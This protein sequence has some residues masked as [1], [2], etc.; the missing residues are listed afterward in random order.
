MKIQSKITLAFICVGAVSVI[1]TSLIIGWFSTDFGKKSLEDA[2]KNQLVSI[3]EIKKTQ[4]ENHF[5]FIEDQVKTSSNNRMIIDAMQEF[6]QAFHQYPDE[7]I[8]ADYEKYR[9]GLKDYY[10]NEFLK[11]Y[12]SVN[13][14]SSLDV[15]QI[16]SE[17]DNESVALQ[18]RYIKDN[19][20][21]LGSKDELVE[22]DGHTN[23][24][25]VH[26]KYH[27]HI[28][29]F[30]K[31]FGYYDI[32]LVDPVTGKIV[33]SVFKELDY[34][35]SL[36]DGPYADSGLAKAFKEANKLDKQDAVYLTD[37]KPYTPS[38]ESPAAFI[39]SPIYEGGIKQGILIFQ[40]PI[41]SINEIMTNNENWRS[42][43]LGE[44]GET[45]LVGADYKMRSQGRFIIEDKPAYIDLIESLGYQEDLVNSIKLKGTT[46]GLQEVES[47]GVKAALSGESGFSIFPDYR[48][49]TVLSAYA[50]V[51]I[52]GMHW[53]IMSEIDK[54]E[55]FSPV[56]ELV[57]NVILY[58]VIAVICLLGLTT[59]AGFV[60]A[61]SISVPL[62]LMIDSVVQC[63]N[64]ISQGR[65]D[66][67]FR[68][69]DSSRDEL[70]E[71]AGAF[72]SF[73]SHIQ[74]II[75]EVTAAAMQVAAAAEEMTM[76]VSNTNAGIDRQI[77]E[78]EQVATAMNEMT[79]TAQDVARSASDAASVASE[80]DEKS[81]L[82]MSAVNVVIDS[83]H[84]VVSEVERT[85]EV[86]HTLKS[87]SESIGTVLD[88]IRDIADQTNLLALNAA[89][90]AARAGEQG[91]GF[92][93]VADEVRT[94]ANRT[95]SSTEEIQKMIESLQARANK[96]D[97]AMSKSCEHVNKTVEN[98]G[99]AGDALQA[100][101]N[102][103]TNIDSLNT[104]IATAA[105]EQT[106]VAEEINRNIVSI[107]D[108]GRE[109]TSGT[110]QISVASQDLAKL[111]TGLQAQVDQ[112]KV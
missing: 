55:A 21:P 9:V 28:R 42:S 63:V 82:G 2:V 5:Q 89:I 111:A 58:S 53:V 66:L 92:A 77:S 45:Y 78:T 18:H 15:N 95:Q 44:S 85:S 33:Y 99:S 80:A 38:Y 54:A 12:K 109:T 101:A 26:K 64:D 79:A 35:T 106:A 27:A 22:T 72:N 69:D 68:A 75:R 57:K 1:S 76:V 49:I 48:S 29:D 103:I 47:E 13:S 36:I 93:V 23:Y 102:V 61:R 73:I 108:I 65:G 14:D 112:F 6:N 97:E 4:I 110:E 105:E 34:A 91:R 94:L 60:V 107:S 74:A 56:T 20:H 37:F 39:A 59:L 41:D 8:A 90:E 11:E 83:V 32:F 84:T 43:G 24:E 67:T 98:A 88:V 100:I 87:D 52:K 70:G 16:I 81:R 30:L 96:A 71:L 104:Q 7:L 25:L 17:F 3:R 10:T 46:I 40:M 62:L 50:P 31:K 19:P 86:I 51:T